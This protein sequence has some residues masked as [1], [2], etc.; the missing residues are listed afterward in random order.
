MESALAEATL[1]PFVGRWRRLVSTTNWEKGRI[2]H[3]WRLA[4]IAAGAAPSEYSDEAWSRAVGTV[5][6]GHV[7][8]LRRVFERF[9][10]SFATYDGLFW[11]HFLA[12]LD[13]DDAEM[14]L[15]GALQSGWTVSA[16]RDQRWQVLGGGPDKVPPVND[17]T[18]AELDEDAE[19]VD[20]PPSAQL[21]RV[22]PVAP[23][24]DD[25]EPAEQSG[26]EGVVG[27]EPDDDELD[28]AVSS[29]SRSNRAV[30]PLAELPS[31]PP[32]VCEAFE[33]FKLCIL[34]HKLSQWQDVSRD[35][36]LASLD[37]LKELALAP[38]E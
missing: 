6:T 11:S 7:G 18:D 38:S 16:M 12:A 5:S 1:V 23:F 2:I 33:A 4:A 35:D 28:D 21:D 31:L 22:R 3:D 19:P 15:E 34:R 37:A 13:W 29:A 20:G 30:R 32:D 26:A 27:D 36:V 8:R 24:D 25:E 17:D 9:G 10:E 14:W